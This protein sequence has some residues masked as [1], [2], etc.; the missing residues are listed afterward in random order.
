MAMSSELRKIF[1][2]SA[3]GA[4]CVRLAGAYLGA[5]PAL[6]CLGLRERLLE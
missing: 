2:K 3:V 5:G 6:A 1:E 4:N